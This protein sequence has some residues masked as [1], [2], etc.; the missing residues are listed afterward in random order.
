MKRII[1]FLALLLSAPASAFEVPKL[2]GPVNDYAKLLTADQVTRLDKSLREIESNSKDG[3]QVVVLTLPS[4]ADESI[5][6]VRNDVFRAWKLGQAGKDNGVLLIIAPNERKI[7]IEVGYGLEAVLPDG[8]TK[9][10]TEQKI[11]PHLKKGSEDWFKAIEGGTQA[12]GSAVLS[13]EKATA[14]EETSSIFWPIAL[15]GAALF[16]VGFVLVGAARRQAK[17]Q[18]H[19]E[20]QAAA[21]AALSRTRSSYTSRSNL[22]A[23]AVGAGAGYT[24]A[25]RP[26]PAPTRS[27]P[28]SS[29]YDSSP[30]YSSSYSSSSS[31]S[32]GSSDSGS[33][34][35]YSGGGGDSGGGGS[36]SDF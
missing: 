32:W 30:S 36:S 25:P 20:Q 33:S 29:S 5:D 12:L 13:R 15:L 26:K 6:Q 28:R 7:G 31:S 23:A 19:Q 4:L 2:V 3:A 34:S 1:L 8:L 11:K 22:A 35:S 14:P 27:V 9:S 10:I 24:A 17:R 21:A 18:E 16:G